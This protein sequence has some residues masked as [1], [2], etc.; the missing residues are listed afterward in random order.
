MTE[1]V[2]PILGWWLA[3]SVLGW[4]AVPLARRLLGGL[5]DRG[6]GFAGRSASSWPATCSGWAA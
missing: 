1:V 3:L 5:P 6:L 4:A 2:L